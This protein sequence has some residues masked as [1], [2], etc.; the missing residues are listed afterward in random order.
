MMFDV[1]WSFQFTYNYWEFMTGV[2]LF[3]NKTFKK[4][5]NPKPSIDDRCSYIVLYHGAL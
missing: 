2:I 3:G 4:G 5:C 1:L